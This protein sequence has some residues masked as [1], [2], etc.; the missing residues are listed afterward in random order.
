MKPAHNEY[1]FLNAV[2][3]GYYRIDR[4]GNIWRIADRNNKA[5]YRPIEKPYI[6]GWTGR[7]GYRSLS[8]WVGGN[9]IHCQIHRIVWI[10]F[11]GEIPDGLEINHKNGVKDDNSLSNLEVITPTQNMLHSYHVTKTSV[12]HKGELSCFA[13][14]KGYEVREIRKRH[15]LGDTLKEIAIS[16]SVSVRAIWDIIHGRTWN[17]I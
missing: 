2:C 16:Y 10:Y 8:M 4:S 14:L 12:I 13:K 1:V 3:H 11:N 7:G 15:M 17:H 5:K 6:I 9:V